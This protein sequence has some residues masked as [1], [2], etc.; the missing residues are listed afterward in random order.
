MAVFTPVSFDDAADFVADY[1]AGALGDIQP[2][3]EGVENTNYKIRLGARDFVL[4]LFEKR[5]RAE[6]VAR[7]L[8]LLAHWANDGLPAPQPLR[9]SDGEFLGILCT[10][11]AAVLEWRPGAWPRSPNVE[12]T[13]NAARALARMHG[14][15]RGFDNPPPHRF[16]PPTW[17][18]WLE[19]CR[20]GARADE[21]VHQALI[22]DLT[23]ELDALDTLWPHDLP[24]TT[25]HGDY[26]P[27]NV[28]YVGDQVTG[29]IDPY[30]AGQ[31]FR[32][33]DLAVAINAWGFDGEGVFKPDITTAFVRSYDEAAPLSAQERDAL[34]ALCRGAAARFTL[35][36]LHDLVF[37]NP[38]WVF[39]PKDPAAFHRRLDLHR[40]ARDCSVYGL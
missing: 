39:T 10:R 38:D 4:T 12:Q 24:S 25:I 28:L 23:T 29:L 36:R 33:Y 15:A 31:D 7:Q 3:T 5:T 1:Q 9:R 14:S 32:A 27:D 22:A 13:K 6:D 37:I 19:Q 30:F 34:P 16:G 2:I 26:F 21:T 11:P 20:E 18:N 8:A 17:R 40:Q 35:S